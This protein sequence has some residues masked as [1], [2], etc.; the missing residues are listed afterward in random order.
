M[1]LCVLI[2]FLVY[3]SVYLIRV[4]IQQCTTT[5]GLSILLLVATANTHTS[6]SKSKVVSSPNQKL[7]ARAWLAYFDQR[8]HTHN[9]TKL[10][11]AWI[12]LVCVGECVCVILLIT[13]LILPFGRE[14]F[15]FFDRKTKT[16]VAQNCVGDCPNER[17]ILHALFLCKCVCV[18]G[19][20]FGES[21]VMR[22][23]T[24]V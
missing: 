18:C 19:G 10:W 13:V 6:K 3:V 5:N 2:V 11:H 8:T 23:I 15:A 22:I 1:C 17:K 14:C 7:L 4:D 20:E 9:L 21:L 16:K 24:I 12:S